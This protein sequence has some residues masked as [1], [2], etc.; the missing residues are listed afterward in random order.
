MS[1]TSSISRSASQPQ[2]GVLRRAALVLAEAERGA[3]A[4]AIIDGSVTGTRS[5][6]QTPSANRSLTSAA[7][8]SASRVLPTPPGPT[9]VTR[10]CS[11]QR[12][13]ER[14][15][16]RPTRPTNGVNGV[17]A[18]AAPAIG[19]RPA[20]P[21]GRDHGVAAT[22]AK[23]PAVVHLELAQ[24]RGDMTLDGADGDEQPRAD[25]GVGQVFAERGQHLGLAR[26]DAHLTRSSLIGHVQI[27][28][29][30]GPDDAR[31]DGQTAHSSEAALSAPTPQHLPPRPSPPD[32]GETPAAHGRKH[33]SGAKGTQSSSHHGRA[34]KRCM[35]SFTAPAGSVSLDG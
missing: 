34:A 26:G 7:T 21:P 19:R 15:P 6:N 25:L 31:T 4:G 1:S 27:V 2:H 9:A 14:R 30:A 22:A 35:Y 11:S 3:I 16:S 23:R 13:G 29:V 24:Q 8:R 12:V 17:G 10:R 28:H 32:P 20:R 5:T 33:A 18:A